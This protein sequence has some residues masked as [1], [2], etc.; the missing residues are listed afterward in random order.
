VGRN[1]FGESKPK[2]G[3]EAGTTP[4]RTLKVLGCLISFL[5]YDAHT[6]NYEFISQ[7]ND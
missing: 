6:L 5:K 7:S 3:L 4:A 2:T 1:Y